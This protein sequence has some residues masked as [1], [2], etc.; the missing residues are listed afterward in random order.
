MTIVPGPVPSIRPNAASASVITIP[1]TLSFIELLLSVQFTGGTVTSH[2]ADLA[3]W[4]LHRVSKDDP[5][6][7]RLKASLSALT[8]ASW[9]GPFRTV[10]DICQAMADRDPLLA[11]DLRDAA[12]QFT[13]L[14]AASGCPMAASHVAAKAV[15]QADDDKTS[16]DEALDLVISAL[17]WLASAG[18]YAPGDDGYATRDQAADASERIFDRVATAWRRR[19]LE[20]VLPD[21]TCLESSREIVRAVSSVVVLRE[22]G[23][24][25]TPEGRRVAEAYRS[26]VGA[27]LPLI[28]LPDVEATRKSLAGKHPHAANVIDAVV[29]ELVGRSHVKMQPVILVGPP[30]CGKTS[31]A[32]DLMR[33]LGVPHVTFPCGGLG[34]PAIAGTGRRW[35]TGE[36]TLP[37]ALM[38]SHKTA[39]PGIVLDEIEKAATGTHH[40]RLQD[41]VLGMLEPQSAVQWMDPYLM[42]P[43][44][45]SHVLWIATANS[46]EGLTAALLDRCRI[47]KVPAPGI[48]HLPQ[49]GNHL[50]REALK[51]RGVDNRWALPL[52]A[53]ELAALTR[54]WRGGSI[55]KLTRLVLG[56]L[57]ERDRAPGLN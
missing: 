40:G 13:Y 26:L 57:A 3:A 17:G 45:L 2:T 51:D 10:S 54:A 31:L 37:V 5:G 6:Y 9:P 32:Q 44:D 38:A 53:V 15:A 16:D 11:S 18:F 48:E 52:D 29:G 14:A 42:A 1:P 33:A 41:A 34:D 46:L 20:Q 30:G 39:S 4:L 21:S 27:A 23:G 22:I 47:I 49:L 56:V 24:L 50:V 43:V 12:L 25:Q 35:S 8:P 19:L 28:A 36:P 7:G 55:R